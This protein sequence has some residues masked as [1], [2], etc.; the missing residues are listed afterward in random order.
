MMK[1]EDIDTEGMKQFMQ[2]W[3]QTDNDGRKTMLLMI[4]EEQLRRES[5]GAI[6]LGN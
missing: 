1:Q 4:E 5:L 2:L 3:M 6:C